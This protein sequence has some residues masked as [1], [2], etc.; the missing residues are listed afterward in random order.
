MISYFIKNKKIIRSLFNHLYLADSVTE[1]LIRLCSVEV[2]DDQLVS[3]EEYNEFVR[4]P[5]IE[6]CV[7]NLDSYQDTEFIV[8]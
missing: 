4:K 8:T 3:M 5:I 1:I 6:N 2:M 7:N